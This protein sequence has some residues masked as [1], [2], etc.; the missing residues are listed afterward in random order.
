VAQLHVIYSTPDAANVTLR[1]FVKLPSARKWLALVKAAQASFARNMKEIA[2]YEELLPELARQAGGVANLGFV[3][4]NNLFS[5]W[6]R[7]FDRSII[8][9]ECVDMDAFHSRPDWMSA[10]IDVVHRIIDS[11][12]DLHRRTWQLERVPAELIASYRER[13]GVDWLEPGVSAL[14]LL[15]RSSFR[16]IWRAIRKRTAREPVVVSHGDCR[17]GNCLLSSDCSE[18]ILTDWEVNSI[19]YYLWD[20]SYC[21]ICSLTPS[22]RREHEEDTIRRYL[23]ALADG[24]PATVVPSLESAMELHRISGIVVNFFGGLIAAFG[25]VGKTHGNSDKDM[26]S[27][28]EKC[29][30]AMMDALEDE[31]ALAKALDVDVALVEEFRSDYRV[32]LA[33][34][35][36]VLNGNAGWFK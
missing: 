27:W 22:D 11:A 31:V 9:Q 8:V 30:A 33:R 14:S 6:S 25:G 3:V 19:T 23:A 2:F 7:N 32:Y 5:T 12:T 16:E 20:I 34:S 1:L 24:S 29:E 28:G 36:D 15:T 17:L 10:D 18:V 21:M 4:P 13:R 26:Q 35:Y